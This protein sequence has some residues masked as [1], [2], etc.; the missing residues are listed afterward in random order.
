M[1]APFKRGW[2]GSGNSML[3][4]ERRLEIDAVL[5]CPKCGDAPYK[6]FRR[7]NMQTDG[8]LLTSFQHVLWPNGSGVNPPVH[9]EYICCPDC[10][11]ELRRSPP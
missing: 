10:G 3:N 7:Q 2:Y 11:K 1:Q 5:R 9:P 8:E 6:V 4:P